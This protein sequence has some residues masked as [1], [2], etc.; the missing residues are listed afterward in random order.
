MQFLCSKDTRITFTDSTSPGLHGDALR[1]IAFDASGRLFVSAG[2]DK[3][4][5]LWDADSWTCIK[6]R[7]V[8]K[9]VSAAAFSAD[10]QWVTYADKF[11]AVSVMATSDS[12]P[13]EAV[14]LLAHCCSIIT[15]LAVSA[16]GNYVA[17]ADRDHKIR[18]SV[19]PQQPVPAGAPDIQSFC[20]GHSSYPPPPPPPHVRLWDP[21]SGRQLDTLLLGPPDDEDDNDEDDNDAT[22]GRQGT[23]LTPSTHSIVAVAAAQNSATIAVAIERSNEVVLLECSSSSRLCLVQRVT[24]AEATPPTGL[25][26]DGAGRL[27]VV[28]GA[29]EALESGDAFITPEALAAAETRAQEIGAAALARVAVVEISG[30]CS[31]TEPDEGRD[32]SSRDTHTKQPAE[33]G[34]SLDYLLVHDEAIPGGPKL[35]ETLQGSAASGAIIA[36][37]TSAAL[38]SA[39]ETGLCK[40]AYTYE[41]REYRK[42]RRNDR[43][44]CN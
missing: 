17:T 43:R 44:N 29:A 4:V 12:C 7:R 6:T 30:Q 3:L 9:K 1:A 42:R 38:D 39:T 14:Q 24:L 16:T 22:R 13:H 34:R 11:G 40:K 8:S 32:T 41:E 31:P 15:S 21:S 33:N 10:G 18:V 25:A 5:K 35:L 19:F 37:A 20:L 27:W 28:S 26:F 2:D 23:V 36:A